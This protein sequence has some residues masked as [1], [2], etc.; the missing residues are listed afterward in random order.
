[1]HHPLSRAGNQR[2]PARGA[3]RAE[4]A[5]EEQRLAAAAAGRQFPGEAAEPLIE[6]SHL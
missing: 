1:M 5:R 6:R 2:S 4:A 3:E